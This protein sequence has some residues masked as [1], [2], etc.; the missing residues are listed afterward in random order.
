MDCHGISQ[1]WQD[2]PCLV[3]LWSL[4]LLFLVEMSLWLLAVTLTQ[5]H[6]P[7]RMN[8]NGFA[9]PLCCEFLTLRSSLGLYCVTLPA[10]PFITSVRSVM[11]CKSLK[12]SQRI[13]CVFYYYYYYYYYTL[14]SSLYSMVT[15]TGEALTKG[16]FFFPPRRLGH[17][18]H[19]FVG[20]LISLSALH[21]KYLTSFHQTWMEDGSWPI[22]DLINFWCLSW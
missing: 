17:F 8:L 4:H 20:W 7:L 5:I 11:H 12:T 9:N 21:K 16:F 2:E 1:L 18:F 14:V 10:P 13:L 6:V 22:I 3:P 15:A 19:L